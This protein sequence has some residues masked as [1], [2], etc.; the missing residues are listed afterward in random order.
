MADEYRWWASD[1]LTRKAHGQGYA[2]A[3]DSVRRGCLYALNTHLNKDIDDKDKIR[4][5]RKLAKDWAR[6]L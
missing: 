2:E 4:E 6:D 5:L 1:P 3:S